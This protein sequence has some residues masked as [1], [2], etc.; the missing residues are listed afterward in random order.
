MVNGGA[1]VVVL[2]GHKKQY[3]KLLLSIRDSARDPTNSSEIWIEQKASSSN[4]MNL[5]TDMCIYF[6][7]RSKDR[8]PWKFISQI[9][10]KFFSNTV[11][12]PQIDQTEHV[13]KGHQ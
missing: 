8:L 1:H 3:G 5:A 13:G 10:K 12:F 6:D 11:L 7:L 4:Q 9:L 2:K